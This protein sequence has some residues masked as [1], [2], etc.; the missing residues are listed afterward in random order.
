MVT[1]SLQT[2][3]AKFINEQVHQFLPT[4]EEYI[5]FGK[6]TKIFFLPGNSFCCMISSGL[7]KRAW[8]CYTVI[9]CI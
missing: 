3:V 5:S 8:G 4:G 2:A 1:F 6:E 7:V 9:N